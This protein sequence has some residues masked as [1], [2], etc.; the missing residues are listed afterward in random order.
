MSLSDRP[1]ARFRACRRRNAGR[2][3]V[4]AA[5]VA[6]LAACGFHLRGSGGAAVLPASLSTVRVVAENLEPY[7]PLAQAVRQALTAAGAKL[8]EAAEAPTLVLVR[9]QLETRVA[10]V[11][12]TTAKAT[13]YLLLYGATFRFDGARAL[14]AQTIRL[15]RD[16]AFDPQ[17]V[18]AKEQ[19][20][21]ELLANMRHEAAQQIVRRVAAAA[22]PGAR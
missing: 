4:A 14:P 6:A 5:L 7:H 22:A 11:S 12:G 16:Y 17:Q 3:A 20:E 10:A 2:V 15:Q 19:Q 1:R 18:L 13:D 8:T 9:E 21:R